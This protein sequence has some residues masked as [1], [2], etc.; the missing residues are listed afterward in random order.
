M[1]ADLK[2]DGVWHLQRPQKIE[3]RDKPAGRSDHALTLADLKDMVFPQV[4]FSD[5]RYFGCASGRSPHEHSA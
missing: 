2:I 1:A 3:A 4:Y 5:D